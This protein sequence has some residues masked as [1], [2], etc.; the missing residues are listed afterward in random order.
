MN[1]LKEKME[2]FKNGRPEFEN[3]IEKQRAK[4]N[5]D[6]R[7]DLEEDHHLWQSVLKLAEQRNKKLYWNLHGFRIAGCKLEVKGE[8]LKMNPAIGDIW[9]DKSEYMKDR[10]QYLLPYKDLIVDIFQE[11]ISQKSVAM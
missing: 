3:F 9:K 7:P 8:S 5:Y 6:P 4:N 2:E 1:Y 10:K 11:A